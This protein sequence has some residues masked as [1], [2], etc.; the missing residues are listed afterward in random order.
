MTVKRAIFLF[1]ENSLEGGKS[2]EHSMVGFL[3]ALSWGSKRKNDTWW[4]FWNFF[5]PREGGESGVRGAGGGG[6]DWKIPEGPGVCLRGIR[7]RGGGAT[8][9]FRGRTSHQGQIDPVLP[10]HGPPFLGVTPLSTKHP[11]DS[12]SLQNANRHRP[13][14]E[15]GKICVEKKQTLQIGGPQFT[16]WRVSIIWPGQGTEICNFGEMSPLDF[17]WIVSNSLQVAV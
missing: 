3:V 14:R 11:Q 6:G 7:G 16:F 5:F 13:K 12:F 9:F 15:V 1:Q 17:S 8:F 2:G 4:T 10:P